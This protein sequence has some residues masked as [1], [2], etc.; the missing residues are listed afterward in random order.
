MLQQEKVT[1]PI[2]PH[3]VIMENRKKLT[4]TG[5]REIDSFNEQLI[6]A[7]TEMGALTIKGENLHINK[8]NKE[9]KEAVIDGKISSFSYSEQKRKSG[10]SLFKGLFK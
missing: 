10:A 9:T 3:N 1:Q 8:L 7:V 6:E 4:I 5:I 2:I